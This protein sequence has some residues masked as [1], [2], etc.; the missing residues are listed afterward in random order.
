MGLTGV[1]AK[2]K[3][4]NVVL[5]ALVLTVYELNVNAA[6]KIGAMIFS[7]HSVEI[8]QTRFHLYHFAREQ[9]L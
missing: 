4:S 9:A 3:I 2:F 1:N 5:Q 6:S 7:V 8:T